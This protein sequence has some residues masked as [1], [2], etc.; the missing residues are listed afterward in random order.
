[1][2]V[3]ARF[4]ALMSNYSSEKANGWTGMSSAGTL[5]QPS[6]RSAALA[7]DTPNNQTIGLTGE[8][9]APARDPHCVCADGLSV[10]LRVLKAGEERL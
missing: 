7:A 8:P 1:M 9:A 5:R 2:P 4:S 3:R 6:P 10:R